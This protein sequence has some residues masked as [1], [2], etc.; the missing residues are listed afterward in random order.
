MKVVFIVLA[1]LLVA[2]VLFFIFF[3]RIKRNVI[4]KNYK[5]YFGKKIYN[6]ALNEDYYLINGLKLKTRL[7]HYV[8]ADHVLFGNKYIYVI[9]DF[10]FVGEI[11]AKEVD[12]TWIAYPSKKG[13]QPYYIKNHLLIGKNNVERIAEETGLDKNFFISILLVN[14]DI[15]FLDLKVKSDT[16]ILTKIK[17][18]KKTIM[19]Y[20]YR[21]IASINDEQLKYAVKD[22][23]AMNVRDENNG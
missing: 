23:A 17:D 18:L 14:N 5:K 9:Q 21:D 10:T 19:S 8:T 12:N 1:V 16:S 3:P 6:I 2:A 11:K 22:I 15:D 4:L 13:G 20:E 7:S